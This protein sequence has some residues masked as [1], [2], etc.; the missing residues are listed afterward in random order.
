[1]LVCFIYMYIYICTHVL[2][3]YI[4]TQCYKMKDV[5][6]TCITKSTSIVMYPCAW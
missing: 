1:M 3:M 5:Y 6:T 2:S 4:H